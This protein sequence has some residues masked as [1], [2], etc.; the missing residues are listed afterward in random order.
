[1]LLAKGKLY[2]ISKMVELHSTV[3]IKA[4]AHEEGGANAPVGKFDVE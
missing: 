4:S 3:V 2:P 1:M